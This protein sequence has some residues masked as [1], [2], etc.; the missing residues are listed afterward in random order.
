VEKSKIKQD[1]STS[2]D[3]GCRGGSIYVTSNTHRPAAS[4]A[5]SPPLLKPL[6]LPYCHFREWRNQ[7]QPQGQSMSSSSVKRKK[8]RIESQEP[9]RIAQ[10]DIFFWGGGGSV[11]PCKSIHGTWACKRECRIATDGR[12]SSWPALGCNSGIPPAESN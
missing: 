5:S 8:V 1:G 4:A 6:I 3:D 2:S 10:S 11:L 12:D 9:A 7:C